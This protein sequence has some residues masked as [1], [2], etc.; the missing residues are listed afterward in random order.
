MTL[1]GKIEQLYRLLNR[2]TSRLT[3]VSLRYKGKGKS[4]VVKPISWR[5][6]SNLLYK[7]WVEQRE[8]EVEKL[9]GGRLGYVHVKGM[10]QPSF[11]KVF[12]DVMGKYNEKEGIVIDTR[13]NGGGWLHNQLSILFT[14][15]S[16]STFAY[17][18]KSYFGG[19]PDNRWSKKSI[20]LVSEGNYSDAHFFAY[21]YRA[22]DI[23]KIVGMPVAGTTTAVWWPDMLEGT[24][25][26]GIP[27][28]GVKDING[29]ILENQE[30]IPDI[31]VENTP[32]DVSN[33]RDAQLE[34]AVEE[35]LK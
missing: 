29:K 14:G 28:I 21:T 2:K 17:R 24:M 5:S 26:F 23:G 16:Y 1:T 32:S 15:K 25:Y 13:F 35:L 19:D 11:H 4:V 22:L 34:R 12:S 3:R 31:V 20:L 18:G 27:Q 8:K 33:G 9:S 6:Q 7:R 10:D 30:L